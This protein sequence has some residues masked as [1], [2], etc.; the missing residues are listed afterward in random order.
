MYD[1][2]TPLGA[3]RLLTNLVVRKFLDN[4]VFNV[5]N[6]IMVLLVVETGEITQSKL[7]VVTLENIGSEIKELVRLGIKGVKL[8][9]P[10]KEKDSKA[11]GAFDK[12]SLMI[13]AIKEI[14]NV[15]PEICI[16]TET[17]LCPYTLNGSCVISERGIIDDKYTQEALITQSLL[18][19][20]A[21]A[22]ILGPAQMLEGMVK[23]LRYFLDKEGYNDIPL[24][25][26]IIFSSSLYNSYRR[27]MKVEVLEDARGPYHLNPNH[28]RLANHY[29]QKFISEGADM[30]LLEPAIFI[31]DIISK[32]RDKIVCPIAAFSVSGEYE[33]IN[34]TPQ[35]SN[36]LILIE[37]FSS[38]RRAGADFIVTYSAKQLAIAMNRCS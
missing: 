4:P 36:I 16:I 6:L 23:T 1:I 21:G 3:N 20:E 12:N 9:A 11:K 10:Y 22:N 33:L 30:L 17:C 28:T 27:T 18:Q 29:A 8:F 5:S 38:L 26:H 34:D 25:P 13:R 35:Q 14:K 15:A 32:V 7:P 31:L 24:M 37:A 2:P 19:V